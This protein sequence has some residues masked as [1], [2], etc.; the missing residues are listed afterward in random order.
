[1]YESAKKG[2]DS[3]WVERKKDWCTLDDE[4]HERLSKFCTTN[5]YVR[6]RLVNSIIEEFLEKYGIKKEDN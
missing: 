6:D 4:L 3:K 2:I 1:M 5:D